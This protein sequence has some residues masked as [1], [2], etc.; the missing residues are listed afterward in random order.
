MSKFDERLEEAGAEVRRHMQRVPLRPIRERKVQW[1]R[2]VTA[3]ALGVVAIAA[4]AT[5]L[6]WLGGGAGED[7]GGAGTAPVETSAPGFSTVPSTT[8]PTTV[9]ETSEPE[10]TTTSEARGEWISVGVPVSDDEYEAL[11]GE[12]PVPGT[13]R[14]LAWTVGYDGQYTLG[15][16]A[17]QIDD[18]EFGLD[19][20]ESGSLY[21]LAFYG[22]TSGE[23]LSV[24]GAGQCAVTAE[25]FAEMLAFG[26]SGSAHC[27]EPVT[28]MWSVWGV[29]ESAASVIFE[30]SDGTR[31][32]GQTV[33]GVA[34]VATGRDVNLRSVSF[35]G[36][37][38]GQLAEIERFTGT[39]Y[40][41]C[42]ESNDPDLPG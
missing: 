22:S 29:P 23:G 9:T 5:P 13:A 35:E 38:A 11:S 15:L 2:T 40:L 26:V 3:V 27:V 17:A 1:H 39:R 28:H 34:Q 41:T 33:N 6:L 24:F 21:C 4:I 37:T 16:L 32:T 42:A 8:Q 30:L 31:L 7:Q 14:R 18:G 25:R 36:L 19:H 12:R 20:E 10:T